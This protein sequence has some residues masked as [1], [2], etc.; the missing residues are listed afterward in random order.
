MMGMFNL[1]TNRDVDIEHVP[2]SDDYGSC[3]S[4]GEAVCAKGC[5]RISDDEDSDPDEQV[6]CHNKL[7]PMESGHYKLVCSRLGQG[8]LACA[9]LLLVCIA[10]G[11]KLDWTKSSLP[12]SDLSCSQFKFVPFEPTSGSNKGPKLVGSAVNDAL[13]NPSATFT[14]VPANQV[15]PDI[16]TNGSAM[17]ITNPADQVAP[18]GFLCLSQPYGRMNN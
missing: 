5:C 10:I 3:G 15:A 8:V 9:L 16:A 11:G 14:T 17:T 7:V 6:E 1:A 18:N 12:C 13:T 4:Q 2:M